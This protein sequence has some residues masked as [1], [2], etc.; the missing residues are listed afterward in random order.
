MIDTAG[1][2]HTQKNL[3]DQLKKICSV[4]AKLEP[5]APHNVM[6]ALDATTGQNALN[7]IR[8]FKDAVSISGL[9]VTKTDGTAK[10]GIVVAI[11]KQY[12]DIS[13]SFV[14]TGEAIDDIEPFCP[15]KF[16]QGLLGL[17]DD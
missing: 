8:V 17:F 4:I 11:A 10:G 7:Q 13:I 16:S 5:S 1:R 14:G 9:V 15:T 12:P 3:M 2:L 6:L